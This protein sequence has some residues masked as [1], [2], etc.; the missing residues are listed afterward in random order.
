[1]S[2]RLNVWIICGGRS[3][4]HE[5]SL[6][7]ARSVASSIDRR[8][9]NLHF[10]T[11]SKQG[12]WV[13]GEP[14][15]LS[16]TPKPLPLEQPQ[17][18]RFPSSCTALSFSEGVRAL[19]EEMSHSPSKKVSYNGN[20]R[21]V[22]F[23]VLHGSY[24]EDGTIQGL[25]EMLDIPY[26]GSNVLGSALAMDKSKAKELLFHNGIPVA[27]WVSFKP[28]VGD[29]RNGR[30]P[31]IVARVIGYPCFVK[32][33]GLGS[34]IG[35]TKVKSPGELEEAIRFART[36]DTK[37]LV[38]EAVD[39]REIEVSVLGNDEPIASLPGEI[40]P[41]NEFYDY[42]AKYVEN[43]TELIAPAELD[44][45][46]VARLRHLAIRAFKVLE[47]CGM[48]RADFFLEKRTGRIIVN[49]L[50]TIPGFTEI[51]MYPRLWE[52]SG[53]SY[54]QLLDRLIELALERY[55]ERKVLS[56]NRG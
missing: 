6:R 11:I 30:I 4:E 28:G 10:V 2:N 20:G 19:M 44:E 35:I 18:D 34:S 25:F 50:N 21:M 26:V 29:A 54:P 27:R 12:E 42:D 5:V 37:V 41:V 3:A 45:E 8:K 31:E 51:S 9:Y 56:V 17:P 1:M 53:I 52:A 36:Y 15:A 16:D 33:S 43:G 38:E 7:S 22:A 14:L 39:A 48:A 24:G 32:P 55:E 23:P 40:V 13:S 49:E 46:Q 47:C